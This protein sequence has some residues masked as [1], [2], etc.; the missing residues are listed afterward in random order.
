MKDAK[1]WLF[2]FCWAFFTVG[3]TGLQFYLPTV[4]A[5]LGFTT[6]ARSQLLNIPTA[7]LTIGFIAIF[8]IWADT[9]LLPRPLYP[10]FFMVVILACYSVLY[11]FPSSGSVYA[12]SIL[13][14]AFSSAWY[15]MMWP[16]RVQ[17]TSKA[18]GSA[19]SIGF[20]NS[21]GQIGGA[22]GPQI[23]RSKYAPRYGTSFSVAMVMVGLAIATNLTTWWFTNDIEVETR[24]LK[25]ARI[26][27]AKRDEAV[28]DDVDLNGAHGSKST[29]AANDLET[30]T[31]SSTEI[32]SVSVIDKEDGKEVA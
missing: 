32:E 30:G 29:P 18:T 4:I 26:E 11:T 7:V 22:L 8:G 13:A 16:W 6:I 24:K 19:F 3:T 25:R 1:T 2:T 9:A 28:L 15:P 14:T 12:A 10:L 17:T 21:Y 27:A 20:V 23:F 31:I 5:N